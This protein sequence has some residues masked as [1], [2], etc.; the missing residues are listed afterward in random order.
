M[1]LGLVLL[2]TTWALA[3]TGYFTGD[4]RLFAWAVYAFAATL[5]VASTPL[6]AFAV[7]LAIEKI[8]RDRHQ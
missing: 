4:S 7:G 5:A 8:V 2:T 6:L 1:F 3:I